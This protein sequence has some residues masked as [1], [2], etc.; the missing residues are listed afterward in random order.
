[1]EEKVTDPVAEIRGVLTHSQATKWR[2]RACA[3]TSLGSRST[4]PWTRTSRVYNFRVQAASSKTQAT[5]DQFEVP[6]MQVGQALSKANAALE[7]AESI[8]TAVNNAATLRDIHHTRQESAME[9]LEANRADAASNKADK[10]HNFS[11]NTSARSGTE[12]SE[13][14]ES[15]WKLK[16]QVHWLQRVSQGPTPQARESFGQGRDGVQSSGFCF[17]QSERGS[18]LGHFSYQI[19][20]VKDNVAYNS[21][22]RGTSKR[23]NKYGILISNLSSDTA[24]AE[25][26]DFF[27][28][29]DGPIAN[30]QVLNRGNAERVA[31]V[32]YFKSAESVSNALK[33]GVTKIDDHPLGREAL[34]KPFGRKDVLA[35]GS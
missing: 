8:G 28:A 30:C 16:N 31:T 25:F 1:M 21:V 32:V 5:T 2:T 34:A 17:E 24:Q 13:Q 19:D 6:K 14:E 12:V 23:N 33:A 7:K 10:A 15:I 26:V 9:S 11:F 4:F 3:R 35:R 27:Q 18:G 20:T 29:V 22:N